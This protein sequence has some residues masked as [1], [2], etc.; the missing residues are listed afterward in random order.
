LTDKGARLI[1]Y[2]SATVAKG[3]SGVLN[4]VS[5][6]LKLLALVVLVAEVIIIIAM[7]LTPPAHPLFDWYP[8]L[9]IIFAVVVVVGIFVDRI[10]ERTSQDRIS[11]RTSQLTLAL[12]DRKVSVDTSRT[13]VAEPAT[14]RRQI[15]STYSDSQKGFMFPH[16]KSQHWS[17]PQHL[18]MGS[19]LVKVGL[20]RNLDHRNEIKEL[21]AVTPLGKMVIEANTD[22]VN[23][24]TGN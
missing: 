21:A 13:V 5:D 22:K 6:W 16:P 11:E 14:L 17:G 9:M 19:L 3:R 15:A 7:N 1:S 4:A 8:V 12:E 20:L 18:H 24:S 23:R 2:I 10:S